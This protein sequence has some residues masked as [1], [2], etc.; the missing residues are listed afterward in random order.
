[1]GM[2]EGQFMAQWAND[3]KYGLNEWRRQAT[4]DLIR[5]N[6]WYKSMHV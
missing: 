3:W 5:T 4:E 2:G 1:M 6:E